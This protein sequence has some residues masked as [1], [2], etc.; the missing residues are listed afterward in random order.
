MNVLFLDM[1]G[2]LN[3][4]FYISKWFEDKQKYKYKKEELKHLFAQQFCHSRQLIFQYHVDLL[5]QVI[6]ATDLK[7]IWSS[8]WRLLE[9]YKNVQDAKKMFN[10]RNL[11]GNALIGYTE[12]FYSTI[13][14]KANYQ[15]VQQI[16]CFINNNTLNIR[17]QD[18]IGAVDD[19]NLSELQNYGIK[20]F[21]TNIYNGLTE[22]IKNEMLKYYLN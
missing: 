17:K 7:I 2:V 11:I 1:D 22:K 9:C 12:R 3:S 8:T 10:R 15:R 19:L 18:K 13:P 20:F 21:Q 6:K 16:L 5:N 14:L 4:N